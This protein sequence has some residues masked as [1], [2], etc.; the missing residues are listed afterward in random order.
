M[1]AMFGRALAAL[2]AA[3]CLATPVS[4]DGTRV[5]AGPFVGYIAPDYDV[6]NGRAH[7]YLSDRLVAAGLLGSGLPAA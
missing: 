7:Q 4:V 1:A 5:N 6:V 3:T 2:A